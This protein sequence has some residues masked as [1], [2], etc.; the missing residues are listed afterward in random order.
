MVLIASGKEFFLQTDTII[1]VVLLCRLCFLRSSI[2]S[3]PWEMKNYVKHNNCPTA[4]K[5]YVI[6]GAD[7]G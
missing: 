4:R 6:K 7:A 3:L 5:E 1:L 2:L